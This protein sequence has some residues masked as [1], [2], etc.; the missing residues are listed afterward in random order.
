[1]ERAID[2]SGPGCDRISLSAHGCPELAPAVSA[3]THGAALHA[4]PVTMSIVTSMPSELSGR[5]RQQSPTDDGLRAGHAVAGLPAAAVSRRAWL[6]GRPSP[7]T[8]YSA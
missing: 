7:T 3:S 5:F 1:M 6:T 8:E 2:E 4:V